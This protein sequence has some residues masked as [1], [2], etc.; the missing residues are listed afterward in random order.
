VARVAVSDF[1]TNLL[2]IDADCRK[3]GARA[4]FLTVPIRPVLPLVENF[5]AVRDPADPGAPPVWVR[6]I[7]FA[8]QQMEE[9]ASSEIAAHF[10]DGEGLD[11]FLER[12]GDCER[13]AGLAELAPDLPVFRYLLAQ[14]LRTSDPARAA[15]ALD[16]CRR[17]D[18]ERQ[19]MEA[20][21]SNLRSL[22]A[23]RRLEVRDLAAG[24]AASGPR[25]LFLDV[26]HPNAEGHALVAA[27]IEGW[28]HTTGAAPF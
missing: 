17:L 6:Q 11:S 5:V 23:S 2:A 15:Q 3:A 10:F 21:N 4:L 19:A 25:D 18:R 27:A 16:A 28:L 14:C 9:P 13:V 1:A 7:D 24:F 8:C 26:V 20:Y 12:P 22:G